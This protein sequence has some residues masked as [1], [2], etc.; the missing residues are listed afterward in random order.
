[1]FEWAKQWRVGAVPAELDEIFQL[2]FEGHEYKKLC[3]VV[4]EKLSSSDSRLGPVQIGAVIAAMFVLQQSDDDPRVDVRSVFLS[5]LW[6]AIGNTAVTRLAAFE[7]GCILGCL[8]ATVVFQKLGT[9]YV[10]LED[11][12]WAMIMAAAGKIQ[13]L[14][15]SSSFFYKG[16][17]SNILA[18]YLQPG[19]INRW[20]QMESEFEK[21]V[22]TLEDGR[23]SFLAYQ[24]DGVVRYIVN[25]MAYKLFA[26]R[27]SEEDRIWM[28]D[29]FIKHQREK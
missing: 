25:E 5:L 27:A 29:Q 4:V 18:E 28:V 9:P 22:R 16:M 21:F 20:V 17:F 3:K 10:F 2:M 15:K 7:Y 8:K 1:M 26:K 23:T 13:Q 24:E 6:G 14:H 19:L 12:V 11:R